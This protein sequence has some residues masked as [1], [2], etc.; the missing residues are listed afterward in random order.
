GFLP[1]PEFTVPIAQP[2]IA[3]V[4]SNADPEGQG[5]VQVR[6]DWQT[7]D[8]T[9]FIRMMSPDA[10]GTDQIT[11][12]RGYVAIPEVGDQVMVN[13][14][15]NHPDRPFV[16][17]GMFH[18]GIGLGGGIDNRVK[19]IQTRSGQRV[20]FTED[21]S[22]IIT[23]KSGNEIHLDTT[24]SNI[25]ITAPETMTLNCKNMN[26]N[27]GEN[28]TT[29]VGMNKSDTIGLNN[30]QSVGAMKM[31]SVLGDTSMFITGKLTE[32]IEGDVTSEVKQG[33]TIIN[34]DQGIE[35]SSNG[36]IS[37]HAQKEVQN[38]SGERSKNF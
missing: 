31:T 18:G 5:R 17:G 35:T 15:H 25:T 21:E 8:T 28:M 4:I 30:T 37:K 24:G 3:T 26:I 14:V 7:N 27:V 36:S 6:F 13:F 10:G 23:D 34:S 29:S 38:N 11:Q 20:V 9:H 22:I 2:Q 32:M 12:N 19:S 33:K 1:K 16:M